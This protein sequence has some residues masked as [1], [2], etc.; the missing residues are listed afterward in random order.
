MPASSY[1]PLIVIKQQDKYGFLAVYYFFFCI[2]QIYYRNICCIF[3]TMYYNISYG[4]NG[5]SSVSV[6]LISEVLASAML[7]LIIENKN[8]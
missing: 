8:L 4:D 6:P 5:L 2:L 1:T 7:L 3:S